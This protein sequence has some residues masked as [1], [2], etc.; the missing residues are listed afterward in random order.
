MVT[1]RQLVLIPGLLCSPALYGHQIVGLSDLADIT[2][3]DHTKHD[4]MAAIAASILEKAPP[5]FAL[6]GLS[7]GGYLAFEI[8][9][10][11]PQRVTKLALLDTNALSD[12]TERAAAR[13][14]L[15][16][17]ADREGIAAVSATLF[18]DWVHASRVA[19]PLLAATVRT[20]AETVGITAYR[21]QTEAIIARTDSRPVLTTIRVPALVLCGRQDA[22]T[23]LAQSE[24][25]AR[26]I[27]GSRLEIIEDCGHLST[28]ERPETVTA[29]MR[30]WLAD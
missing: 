1:R 16:A 8:M 25:I 15:V 19:E 6:A 26:G 2:V 18:P 14:S 29:A 28:L 4:T 17:R 12:P 9:R 22:A 13:R 5:A 3:A 30:A 7:M 11:A 24:E 21:R 10:Q 23:P 27:A 20:M